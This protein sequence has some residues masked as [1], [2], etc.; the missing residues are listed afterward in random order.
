M[1]HFQ[2]STN[3]PKS[4]VPSTFLKETTALLANM[5]GKPE[6]VSTPTYQRHTLRK[7]FH[8]F[9]LLSSIVWRQLFPTK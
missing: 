6:S 7:D 8:K 9:G 4:S 1:P 3:V 2:V 5:L